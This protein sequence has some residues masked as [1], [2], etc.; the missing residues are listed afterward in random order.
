MVPSR[1]RHSLT[2]RQCCFAV[3]P[4]RLGKVSSC[5]PDLKPGT[6]AMLVHAAEYGDTGSVVWPGFDQRALASPLATKGAVLATGSLAAHSMA[7]VV[8][9]RARA[10]SSL[11][12]RS[13][14]QRRPFVAH[15]S[16]S[17]AGRSRPA[18]PGAAVPDTPE[19]A[20]HAAGTAIRRKNLPVLF[21]RRGLPFLTVL[22]RHTPSFMN[23]L[24]GSRS[25]V[26]RAAD[27]CIL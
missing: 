1:L 4:D 17:R 13:P 20:R 24:P 3:K 14:P 16:G 7:A 10:A 6:A 25:F 8:S 15:A 27:M 26:L 22:H 5:R 19:R 18:P 11:A 23:V 9:A 12:S 2:M 21:I